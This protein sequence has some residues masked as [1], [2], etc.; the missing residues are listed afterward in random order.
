MM[1]SKEVETN[2]EEKVMAGI[3]QIVLVTETVD[4][5]TT[6]IVVKIAQHLTKSVRNV[7]KITIS[8]PCARVKNVI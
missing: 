4:T 7:E 5:V 1:Q 2:L 3:S 6:V 8:K